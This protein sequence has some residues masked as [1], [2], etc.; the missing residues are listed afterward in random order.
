MLTAKAWPSHRDRVRV[1]GS[2]LGNTGVLLPEGEMDGEW[3]L[4][5]EDSGGEPGGLLAETIGHLPFSQLCNNS[6]VHLYVS[7]P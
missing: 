2:P 1:S 5:E 6:C 4:L 3:V 7:F